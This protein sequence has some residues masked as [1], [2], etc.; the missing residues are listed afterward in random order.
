MSNLEEF[1]KIFDREIKKLNKKIKDFTEKQ[2]DINKSLG[3][4]IWTIYKKLLEIQRLNSINNNIIKK[5]NND[6][7]KSNNLVKDNNIVNDNNIHNI[8]NNDVV[9][10]NMSKNE[11]GL[12]FRSQIS[13]RFK[14]RKTNKMNDEV[15]TQRPNSKDKKIANNYESENKK[16]GR[17]KR[18]SQNK[19]KG[20][21]NNRFKNNKNIVINNNE[22]DIDDED[23]N[24]NIDLNYEEKEI[25]LDDEDNINNIKNEI[26]ENKLINNSLIINNNNFD[27]VSFGNNELINSNNLNNSKLTTTSGKYS[28]FSFNPQ[29]L[30]NKL[31]NNIQPKMKENK[32]I[33]N[34]NRNNLNQNELNNN[35]MD[36]KIEDI[37]NS[38]IITNINEVKLILNN[39]PS[40][41]K[42]DNLPEFQTLFQS[43]VDGD[44]V[45]VFHKFCDG[46]PN[47]IFL[48]QSND[49]K[50]FGGYTKIGFS[51][52][53]EK[54]MDEIAFLFSFDEKRIYK[55]KKK[56]RYIYCDGN[57]G[58]CFGDKENI[59]FQIN[60]NYLKEKSFF[61]KSSKFYDEV[62]SY[63]EDANNK[64]EFVVNKLEIIKILM[65]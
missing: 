8:L 52:D 29:K 45:K 58:P 35:L 23:N 42:F 40:F 1:K 10:N 17:K 25:L 53:G 2:N 36:Y 14:I 16:K 54:K 27:I 65:L 5:S 56:Y 30:A 9:E 60:D 33:I 21:N 13:S 46:E 49:G 44:S 43:S 55:I 34:P 31:N 61:N 32:F 50:R 15:S 26:E 6:L 12:L 7:V 41:N 39:L 19:S 28:E 64:E 63:K 59:L 51:S 38:E 62:N 20:K 57:V 3:A 4:D 11:E 47:L 24:N 48:I 37:L 18:K 22:D